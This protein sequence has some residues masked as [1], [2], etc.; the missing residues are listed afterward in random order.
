MKTKIILNTIILFVFFSCSNA[1]SEVIKQERTVDQFSKIDL[2]IAAH[3]FLK[4]GAEQ[5]VVIEADE[6]I[7]E[8][9]KTVV[10]N[11]TLLI[12][13]DK[14]MLHYKNVNVYITTPNVDGLDV[15]GSGKIEALTPIKTS[16][17][18]LDVSGSGKIYIS[19][20]NADNVSADISGSGRINL[21]GK[22]KL[23]KLS[24]DISGSGKIFCNEQTQNVIGNISGS[25]TGNVNAT[26][27]L[28]VEISGSGKVYYKGNPL[29]NCDISGSGKLI[30]NN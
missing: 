6:N 28:N 15:S 20:L 11:N 27:K 3:V 4:Q 8:E 26:Q 29:I 24:F 21:E 12:K 16:N 10:N 5:S 18:K 23:T 13:I 17:L 19:E 25:G 14:W 1:N 9:I 30:E 7:I 22:T 2:S